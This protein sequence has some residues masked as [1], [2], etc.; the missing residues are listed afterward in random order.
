MLWFLQAIELLF[1]LNS[2]TYIIYIAHVLNIYQGNFTYFGA[3]YFVRGSH[4]LGK[5]SQRQKGA[6]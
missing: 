6:L 3:I 4:T 1:S 2:L 5:S